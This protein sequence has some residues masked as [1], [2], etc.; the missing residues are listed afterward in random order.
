M[1]SSKTIVISDITLFKTLN[2]LLCLLDMTDLV[3]IMYQQLQHFFVQTMTCRICYAGSRKG[4]KQN[5]PRTWLKLIINVRYFIAA[6]VCIFLCWILCCYFGSKIK[7]GRWSIICADKLSHRKG[8]TGNLY[9]KT[10]N[11]S[12]APKQIAA[13]AHVHEGLYI[14]L[15]QW[16]V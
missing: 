13:L 4:G 1:W 3:S 16:P 15:C 8:R 14:V 10:S 7:L 6:C 12:S 5:R 2:S 11:C 9:Y